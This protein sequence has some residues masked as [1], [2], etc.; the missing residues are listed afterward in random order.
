MNRI[1]LALF[2]IAFVI[3]ASEVDELAY[4]ETMSTKAPIVDV[5][6]YQTRIVIE[7]D[8][9]CL[10]I[11]T[12]MVAQRIAELRSQIDDLNQLIKRQP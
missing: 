3:F 7:T 1:V 4:P 10:G 9:T 2:V 5:Y 6:L 11:L 12:G 8:A